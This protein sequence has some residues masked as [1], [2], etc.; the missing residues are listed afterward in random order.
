MS[1][2]AIIAEYNPFHNGHLYHLNESKRITGAENAIAVMSGNFVQRGESAVLPKLKRAE[3]AVRS[4]LDIVFEMPVRYSTASAQDFAY[5]GVEMINSLGIADYLSFGTETNDIDVLQKISD[6]LTNETASF[7]SSL[8]DYLKEGNS[9]PKARSLALAEELGV[10]YAEIM[11]KPNNI[12]A[13]EYLSALTKLDS[14]I[15]PVAVTR[16][17]A[18]HDGSISEDNYASGK[19]IREMLHNND[20]ITSFMPYSIEDKKAIYGT[21]MESL[22]NY[23]LLKIKQCSSEEAINKYSDILDITPEL[24]N[25]IR[26][27]TLPASYEDIIESLKSKEI[28]RSRICRVLIHLL[29]E[30]K[31]IKNEIYCPYATILALRKDSSGLL[32]DTGNRSKIELINKRSDYNPDNKYSASLYKYDRKAT[33]LYNLLWYDKYKEIFRNELS[34][35]IIVF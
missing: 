33:D 11:S 21:D 26:N 2:V 29:L 1:T 18:G 6:C 15:K 32:R 12:L 28:T 8:N 31:D 30:I 5:A 34:S 27:L 7:K 3:Y 14:S 35:N 23:E 10:E 16:I 22:L 9:Y 4:G 17:G 20:T 24:I 19:M 13:I 25:K